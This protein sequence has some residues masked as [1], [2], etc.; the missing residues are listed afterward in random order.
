MP[1]SLLVKQ[2]IKCKKNSFERY[3]KFLHRLASDVFSGKLNCIASQALK[4]K[5]KTTNVR[6]VILPIIFEN[7]FGGNGVNAASRIWY[8]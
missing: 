2:L 4:V 8:V 1:L 6:L 5:T 3:I 7:N